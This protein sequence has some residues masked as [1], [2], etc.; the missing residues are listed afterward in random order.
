MRHNEK[1]VGRRAFLN[2]SAG[3]AAAAS[4]TTAGTAG[5][6]LRSA[7]TAGQAPAKEPTLIIDSHIHCGETQE[8]VNE[9]VRVYRPRKAMACV[10]TR[11]REMELIRK[12]MKDHPDIVIGYGYVDL[13]DPNAVREVE[14]FHANGFVGMKFHSPRKDYDD[15]DYFQVYR[16]CEH[17]RMH[18]LF[19]TG[20][21]SRTLS[22]TPRWQS[23]SRMRPMFLDTLCRLFPKTTIQGAHLGNPWY[24]EA[25]EAARWNPNLY[26]DVTGSTLLKFIKLGR[27]ERMSEVLWWASDEAQANPHTLK[28]GPGAWEHIVFGTDEEPSGLQ[29]NIERFQKM[30]D[31]NK[32]SASDRDKMWGLTIARIL[33][34]DPKTRLLKPGAA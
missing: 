16:L 31:A 8:W 25:A 27:L 13:D 10:L 29:S 11:M 18:M 22:D 3:L 24:E 9:L 15:S 21:T 20:V 32:V 23:A 30:L 12:A 26:F 5:V 14:T 19:H 28:G 33:D 4:V 2:R 6:P 34:I 1:K 7:E 17:Y